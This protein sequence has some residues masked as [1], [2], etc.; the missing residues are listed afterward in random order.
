MSL[1]T[2]ARKGLSVPVVSTTKILRESRTIL[3][4]EVEMEKQNKK[5]E[6]K[7]NLTQK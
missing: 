5:M 6:Q 2:D 7:R 4:S 3:F 1:I